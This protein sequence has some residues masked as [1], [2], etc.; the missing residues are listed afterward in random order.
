M[1]PWNKLPIDVVAAESLASFKGRL[2][3]HFSHKGLV[4]TIFLGFFFSRKKNAFHDL[5]ESTGM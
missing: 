4:H 2:D 3:K 5:F 1:E